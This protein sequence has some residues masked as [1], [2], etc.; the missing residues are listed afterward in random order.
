MI[1]RGCKSMQRLISASLDGEL[2]PE[3]EQHLQAHLDNCLGCRQARDAY[4]KNRD[5]I[6]R[7][8][9]GNADPPQ[10]VTDEILSRT[11]EISNSTG[12]RRLILG[13][14]LRLTMSLVATVAV[15]IIASS[16]FLVQN[17]Q[18]GIPP[19]IAG[20][21]PNPTQEVPFWNPV[22][23]TFSRPMNDASVMN[24]LRM[25]PPRAQTQ[26]IDEGY[27]HW[28]GSSLIIGVG[29]Q[30]QSRPFTPHTDYSIV[31]MA[32]AKDT[33]GNPLGG[34]GW[35]VSFLTTPNSKFAS[36][37]SAATASPTAT[38]TSIA[39][40]I[41]TSTATQTKK[42]TTQT[43]DAS[44]APT[45]SGAISR[46]TGT[47][48]SQA[49]ASTESTTATDGASPDSGAGNLGTS[50]PNTGNQGTQTTNS[51]KTDAT[52]TLTGNGTV[53]GQSNDGTQTSQTASST[54][55]TTSSA[56]ST[57]SA[58]EVTPTTQATTS[59]SAT[60]TD[61]AT[62]VSATPTSSADATS[63]STSPGTTSTTSAAATDGTSTAT[64][65]AASG[66]CQ[67]PT[68]SIAGAAFGSV[69]W[70]YP[71]VCNTLGMPSNSGAQVQTSILTF[72]RGVM[73][74][75]ADTKKIY[76]L[77]NDGTGGSYTVVDAP[78]PS[79]AD[80]DGTAA[81]NPND[82]PNLWIP[83]GDLGKVWS[84]TKLLGSIGYATSQTTDSSTTTPVQE[85]QNGTMVYSDAGW[86]YVLYN[87]GTWQVYPDTSGHGA[88]LE[89]PT[90]TVPNAT[91]A[92]SPTAAP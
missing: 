14:R 5:L 85:F 64:E 36:G 82:N 20:F 1:G 67:N 70:A 61:T 34:H 46:G 66:K 2:S 3:D 10:F 86:V 9:T 28:D 50:N 72:Q 68:A 51:P 7:N 27:Y 63:G 26:F 29:K 88:L 77:T 80:T 42:S 90:A 57:P 73:I 37:T 24:N 48:Q 60:S 83:S 45:S 69:Y 55:T 25:S 11:R 31:V 13:S 59:S 84:D 76:I 87:D 16:F 91:P 21:Q 39:Q 30:G 43:P 53:T 19:T 22:T 49:N 15:A 35:T 62:T 71:A 89:T 52:N 17:Y 33:N 56:S 12:I 4:R 58:P 92:V 8:L 44:G 32:A 74:E 18:N 40:A 23:V 47:A 81:P 6:Q 78:S 38:N 41:A 54:T 65:T 75:R 79:M